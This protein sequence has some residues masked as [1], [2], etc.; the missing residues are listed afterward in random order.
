MFSYNNFRPRGFKVWATVSAA[1][2]LT[3]AGTL[4][5]AQAD[6]VGAATAP[7]HGAAS[8]AC[9]YRSF[10]VRAEQTQGLP[11][12]Y[13]LAYSKKNDALWATGTALGGANTTATLA[14]IDPQTMKIEKTVALDTVPY[15]PRGGTEVA[16]VQLKGPFG[17]DV[18]DV[19][20]TVW[21]TN[22]IANEVT[23]Y[24]QATL[25]EVFSTS[26]L[27]PEERAK[28][29]FTHPREVRIADGKAFVGV[30]GSVV[31]FDTKT[32]AFLQKINVADVEDRATTVMN[33]WV[34][35]SEGKAYFPVRM[36]D[37]VKI[38]DLKDLSKPIQVVKLHKHD[39]EA[40]LYAS[41]VVA[42]HSLNEIYVSSQGDKGK[43]SGVGVYDK[44][45]GEFKK[46]IDLGGRALSLDADEDNDVVYLTDFDGKSP[47]RGV[48]VIDGRTHTVAAIVPKNSVDAPFGV[49]DVIVTPKGVFAVDKGGA[50]KNAEVPFTIDYRTG[51]FTT[52][53][54]S[55]L[56]VQNKATE[57]APADWQP[58]EPTPI[59][60]DTLVK[61]TATSTGTVKGQNKGASGADVS[62]K[63]VESK[64]DAGAKVTGATVVSE[65]QAIKV[66]GT[67]WKHP[68][69]TGGSTVAVKY[70]KGT[71]SIDGNAVIA[72]VEADAQGKWEMNLPYPTTANSTV[73]EGAW[74][75]GTTHTLSFLSGTLKEG[76]ASR[77]ANFQIS[78][79]Q[80]TCDAPEAKRVTPTTKVFQGY[81]TLVDS[82]VG[83]MVPPPTDPV[84]QDPTP[85]PA[86][87]DPVKQD[88]T[89]SP[90]P[91]DPVKQ[92]PTPSPTPTDPVKQDP[93]VGNEGAGSGQK[94]PGA[95]GADKEPGQLGSGA[96]SG[97]TGKDDGMKSGRGPAATGD[98]ADAGDAGEKAPASIA[99]HDEAGAG[100]G[101]NSPTGNESASGSQGQTATSGTGVNSQ[102]PAV[103]KGS[104]PATQSGL[105]STG[106]GKL[107]WVAGLGAAATAAGTAVVALRRKKAH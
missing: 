102:T 70:D 19:N 22:T 23:A 31:V 80:P 99:D 81:G 94:A 30:R 17:I 77:G 69:G 86:P 25:K 89:P 85:S 107:M 84:K 96:P 65:G 68:N 24:D 100:A 97:E 39:P 3:F 92:D 35:E 61:L 73:K 59:N 8:A 33:M 29:E 20:N 64:Q 38:Y 83:E 9:E 90:A 34:D 41:D 6:G 104:A 53:S 106:A 32:Y 36:R 26:R 74:G 56:G 51:K 78:V 82:K 79:A 63:T 54:T 27:S 10:D 48:Y 98:P 42:D 37:E 7:A 45:T 1:T 101:A 66:S 47:D 105:A 71:V 87:T 43:N 88:P 93:G 95:D 15:I 44:T 18:D 13:Q 67:G 52:S 72:T 28:V 16:G 40:N 5:A 4:T 49:N 91:T 75:P 12:Q 76:D 46:W 11:G 55:V 60:A 62:V 21:V 14:K 103:S 58:A 2:A 57:G 50:Y